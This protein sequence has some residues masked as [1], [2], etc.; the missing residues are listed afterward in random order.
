MSYEDRVSSFKQMLDDCKVQTDDDWSRAMKR[1]G[2]DPRMKLIKKINEKKDIFYNYISEKSAREKEANRDKK[3]K[4]KEDYMMMLSE[5]KNTV[6][7]KSDAYL[8][9]TYQQVLPKIENDLRFLNIDSEDDR[10]DYFYNFLYDLEKKEKERIRADRKKHKA[11]FIELLERKKEQGFITYRTM[12]RQFKDKIQGEEAYRALE[13]CDRLLCWQDFISGLEMEHYKKKEQ[14]REE[15]KRQVRLQEEKFWE[16]LIELKKQQKINV[17]SGWKEVKL[18][19]ENDERYIAIA[20]QTFTIPSS[21]SSYHRD[22]P[23][24]TIEKPKKIFN[25]YID[26]LVGVYKQDKKTFRR[27]AKDLSLSI[28]ENTT[29]DEFLNQLKQ[30]EKYPAIDP[31]NLIILYE[32]AVDKAK[33]KK[34]KREGSLHEEQEHSQASVTLPTEEALPESDPKQPRGQ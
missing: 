18:L 25:G 1:V 21:P 26:Y 33:E 3:K 7:S 5:L 29:F 6:F 28:D 11:A 12:W 19:V 30:D 14:K 15:K 34:R 13:Y 2:N 20:N 24:R 8:T 27:L 23:P 32:E 17:L 9:T 10:L 16:Y 4:L 22:E 31:D